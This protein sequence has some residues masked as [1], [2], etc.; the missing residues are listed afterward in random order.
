MKNYK[1][2]KLQDQGFLEQSL[3]SLHNEDGKKIKEKDALS[4]LVSTLEKTEDDKERAKLVL[5]GLFCLELK[6]K[7]QGVLTKFLNKTKY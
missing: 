1:Q 4:N 6:A 5:I 3:L 2:K 7:D